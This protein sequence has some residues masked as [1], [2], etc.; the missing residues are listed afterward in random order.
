ME[1]QC[2]FRFDLFYNRS[3]RNQARTRFIHIR[4]EENC[5]WPINEYPFPLNYIRAFHCFLLDFLVICNLL[6]FM[7]ISFITIRY[8]ARVIT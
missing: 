6:T 8:S 3:Y 1:V 5:L 2:R 7:L 4:Y